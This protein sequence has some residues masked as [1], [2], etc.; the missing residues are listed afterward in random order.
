MPR[1]TTEPKLPKRKI[2]IELFDEDY[3]FLNNLFGKG[4]AKEDLGLGRALRTIIRQ[5]VNGLRAK[6]NGEL[7]KLRA[8]ERQLGEMPE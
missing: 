7:D 1:P 3:E 6:Q 4:G 2:H 5:K 8:A